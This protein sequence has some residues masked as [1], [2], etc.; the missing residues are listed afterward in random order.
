MSTRAVGTAERRPAGPGPTGSP[1]EDRVLSG[2]GRTS[3][4][5]AHVVT[6][7]DEAGVAAA[8]AA[9]G[10][11]GLIARGL[12]RSYGDA[13]QRAGGLVIEATGLAGI[14]PIGPSG[15]VEVGAGV[16]LHDLMTTALPAGWFV[17]VSP[18]TRLVTVG[19]A[20]AADIHGKNHHRD[21]SFGQHVTELTVVTPTG[22]HRAS[23][24]HRA[25]L[26]WATV[27]G[28]GLTGVITR[29]TLRLIAVETSSV[30]VDTERFGDLDG[31][32]AAMESTDA[33]YRY[34][35]A[36]VD[37]MARGRHLGRAVLTRGDHAPLAALDPGR[38]SAARRPPGPARVAVPVTAPRGLLNPLS[39]SAFNE[40]WFRRS[41]RRQTAAPHSIGSFFHPL[42]G[43]AQWNLL[44]GPAGF[45]Q[46]QFVVGP[47][48]AE[49][50]RSA[51]E[52]LSRSRI[53]SFLAVLKR[54]GPASPGLLSFPVAGWT[55]ALDF[56]LGPPALRD[57]LEQLDRLVAGAGGRVYLAKDARLDPHYLAAM[58]PGST[59]LAELRATIDPAGRLRSDLSERLGLTAGP[60]GGHRR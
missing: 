46:Y 47:E 48:H 5:V 3:P 22:T 24:E 30:L 20:I 54:F 6:P 2:W 40:L 59:A 52:V 18:G 33:D 53:P 34:S 14:G 41:P 31:V 19:G 13:A 8:V 25:A 60:T 15:L 16:S 4:V 26:F 23:P 58:Y 7:A 43:V 12:G 42:D 1:V 36:W 10:R 39:V 35:V 17:P 28:M 37:C 49:V 50:V 45:V 56:P 32:M 11:R 21:G 57:L 29:A 51:V 27:G 38:R 55:L 9:G 44:Y